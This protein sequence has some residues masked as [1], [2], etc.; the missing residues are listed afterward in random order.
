MSASA[1]SPGRTAGS[2]TS[3]SAVSVT[4]RTRTDATSTST[5]RGSTARSWPRR[6]PARSIERWPRTSSRASCTPERSRSSSA[7]IPGCAVPRRIVQRLIYHDDH[8]HVRIGPDPKR[9]FL[10]GRSMKGRPIEAVRVGDRS[11]EIK[12]LV[13]GCIHGNECAGRAV[14]RI[15]ARSSPGGRPLARTEPEPGRTGAAATVRTHTAS[16]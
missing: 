9:Q 6:G 4:P 12:A 15:L 5:T 2:S 16:T 11:S 7:R 13:V 1:T 8:M 14:T 3:A 10:I